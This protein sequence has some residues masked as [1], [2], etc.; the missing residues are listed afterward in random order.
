[1]DLRKDVFKVDK[2]FKFVA[3]TTAQHGDPDGYREIFLKS[4]SHLERGVHPLLQRGEAQ[5][6]DRLHRAGRQAGWQ[7]ETD[8]RRARP[9]TGGGAETPG[10]GSTVRGLS[11]TFKAI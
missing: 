3:D 2:G 10:S 1:M 7:G 6:R 11:V 8:L 9:Q 4:E 5:Q